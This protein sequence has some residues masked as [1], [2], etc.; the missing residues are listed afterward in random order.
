MAGI[1]ALHDKLVGSG[2]QVQRV[3]VIELL[4]DVLAEGVA[5]PPWRY[6]PAA[7]VIGV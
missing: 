2:D 4:A 1:V 6:A 7:P 5:R 3:G